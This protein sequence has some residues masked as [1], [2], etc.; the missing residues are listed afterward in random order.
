MDVLSDVLRT[1]RLTGAVY[2]LVEARAPWEIA[3]PD[4]A[5]LAPAVLPG[6][7]RVISY[8]V[9]TDGAC[10]G[11]L[12]PDGAPTRLEA[13]D[14]LVFPRG[15]P[16]VM[17]IARGMMTTLAINNCTRPSHSRTSSISLRIFPFVRL[18]PSWTPGRAD[19]R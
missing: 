7:Q 2:F 6:A 5:T 14:V 10:W 15:D 9:I 13:G 16:Y 17:S 18:A 12:L 1:V 4:S 11:R 19:P 8:H 3:M